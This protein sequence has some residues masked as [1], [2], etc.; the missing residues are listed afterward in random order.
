MEKAYLISWTKLLA[1]ALSIRGTQK[2]WTLPLQDPSNCLRSVSYTHL[3]AHETDSYLVCR[4]LLEKKNLPYLPNLKHHETNDTYA[5][6]SEY[7]DLQLFLRV[8]RDLSVDVM[9]ISRP[10]A[11]L[12]RAYTG[13]PRGGRNGSAA[14][15]R[16]IARTW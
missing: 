15:I 6:S 10:V 16:R 3:R 11:G 8:A 4:L 9:L 13:L 14:R 12:W 7:S 5:T 2:T 1:S